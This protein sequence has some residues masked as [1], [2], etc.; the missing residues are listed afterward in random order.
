VQSFSW[1]HT[2]A[3]EHRSMHAWLKNQERKPA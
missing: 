2:Q 1:A 3:H